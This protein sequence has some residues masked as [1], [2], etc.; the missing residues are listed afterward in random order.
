MDG[1]LRCLGRGGQKRPPNASP[2]S[3]CP[4]LATSARDSADA[5]NALGLQGHSGFFSHRCFV[6]H[7]RVVPQTLRRVQVTWS[8]RRSVTNILPGA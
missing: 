6:R 8:F 5:S 4:L 7:D 3:K 2:L 1:L